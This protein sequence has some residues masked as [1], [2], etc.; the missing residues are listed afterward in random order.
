MQA[1]DVLHA[2]Q[3]LENGHLCAVASGDATERLATP[4][5][6]FDIPCF[7]FTR[8][9]RR[10]AQFFPDRYQRGVFD[11]VKPLERRHG[12]VVALGD[13]SERFSPTHNMR[14]VPRGCPRHLDGPGRRPPALPSQRDAQTLSDADE[15]R[16]SESVQALQGPSARPVALRNTAQR[17][18][19]PDLMKSKSSGL[20]VGLGPRAERGV[21]PGEVFPRTGR[22]T[23][24]V[25]AWDVEFPVPNQWPKGRVE[26]H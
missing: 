13:L 7:G 21:T 12:G 6:V 16:A 4:D 19:T 24:T 9:V 5:P 18:P 1:F 3:T 17:L 20:L 10:D 14:P 2:I 22:D 25:A 11:A 8:R 15:M 26:R 23:Q